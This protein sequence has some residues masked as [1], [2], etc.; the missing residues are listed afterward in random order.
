M[1][2]EK[3][4]FVYAVDGGA[5]NTLLDVAHKLLSPSTYKC[6]LCMLTYGALSARR[7]WTE[8]L[9]QLPLES[10]FLHRDE[11]A[12]KSP[13]LAR[14]VPAV[15]V[16]RGSSLEPL[17]GSTAINRCKSLPELIELVRA[18]ALTS[19]GAPSPGCTV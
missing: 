19:C 14:D 10:E 17:I 12:A 11:L 3:L 6:N 9:A 8:F 4:V 15:L 13:E 2:D 5:L 1:P 18:A 7:E 16:Q